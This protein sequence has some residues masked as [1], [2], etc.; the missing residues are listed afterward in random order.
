MWFSQAIRR[1]RKEEKAQESQETKQK[2]LRTLLKKHAI[3]AAVGD[4]R[5][6][7]ELLYLFVGWLV[8]V[9]AISS[10]CYF[11]PCKLIQISEIDRS[12]DETK[13][14]VKWPS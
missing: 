2:L 6:N 14:Y 5:C 1:Q 12:L 4:T 11:F 8:F 13:T 10:C 9:S 3:K 7:I